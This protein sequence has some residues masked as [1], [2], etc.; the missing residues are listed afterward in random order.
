[1]YRVCIKIQFKSIK[2][3]IKI[4]LEKQNGKFSSLRILA[5]Q[6]PRPKPANA[7][8]LRAH[9]RAQAATWAWT[10][11]APLGLFDTQACWLPAHLSCSARSDD[12]TS[13]SENQ[14]PAVVSHPN[15]NFILFS[16]PFSVNTEQSTAAT[17][18]GDQEAST[19]LPRAPS[20][21][22]ALPFG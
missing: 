9:P 16:S 10:R 7:L 21:V 20:P 15:P 3:A 19:V 22:H 13:I 11:N 8:A 5:Q 6:L 1:L 18:H 17:A 2:Y 12:A 14:N 4:F